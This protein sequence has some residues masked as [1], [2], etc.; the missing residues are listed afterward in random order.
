MC[1]PRDRLL[2]HVT[3]HLTPLQ[4]HV[5]P[6]GPATATCGWPAGPRSSD[7]Y[8]AWDPLL[9][10]VTDPPTSLQRHVPPQG[11]VTATCDWPADPAPATCT[12]LGTGSSD[13]YLPEDGLLRHVTDHPALLQRHVPPGGPATATCDWPADTAPATCAFRRTGSSDMWV[14]SRPCSSDMFF[15]GGPATATMWRAIRPCSSDMYLPED[16]LLRHVTGHPALLQ[17]HVPPGERA[18]ATCDGPAGP[19]PA[20]CA[21]RRTSFCDM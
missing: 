16:R 7:M 19:A 18:P 2:R 5:L 10:H 9:R 15:P 14:A 20:T 12:S 3:G 11:R 8:L 17:R 13:M 6:A 1:L 4:R 21:S